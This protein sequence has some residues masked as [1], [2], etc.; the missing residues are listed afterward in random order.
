MSLWDPATWQLAQLVLTLRLPL[1]ELGVWLALVTFAGVTRA[2]VPDR[3]WRALSLLISVGFMAWILAPP[4]L[5]FLLATA[6]MLH[7]ICGL[8]SKRARAWAFFVVL[9]LVYLPASMSTTVLSTPLA[10]L[11]QAIHR[12]RA[13]RPVL[14]GNQ[15][16]RSSP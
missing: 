14:A 15:L 9:G 16:P 6:C 12:R 11:P 3:P 2:I 10:G 7:G 5:L 8:E 1:V 4:L 13:L